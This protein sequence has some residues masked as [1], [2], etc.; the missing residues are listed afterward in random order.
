MRD[1]AT[2][3]FVVL[4]SCGWLLAQ[5]SPAPEAQPPV[6]RSDVDLVTLHVTV[7]DRNR[8][9]VRGLTADDFTVIENG[10]P[11]AIV[12]LDAIEVPTERQVDRPVWQDEVVEDVVTN[13]PS[14]GRLVVI[15]FDRSIG[16]GWATQRARL[17]AQQAIDALGPDD[18]AAV[19][20]N[21]H[22]STPVNF[23]SNRSR[24]R[25]A[26]QSPVIGTQPYEN[27]IESASCPCGLCAVDIITQVAAELRHA[28]R[29]PKMLLYIGD[30][31]PG[32]FID[33]LKHDCATYTVPATAAMFDAAQRSQLVIH[34]IETEGPL[35]P[36]HESVLQLAGETGGRAVVNTNAPEAR[37]SEIFH[38][39]TVSYLIGFTPA[40]ETSDTNAQRVAVRV[41]GDGYTV[42]APR[43]Y[44]RSVSISR[45]PPIVSAA[46]IE[47]A[48][49]LRPVHT[50]AA[51]AGLNPVSEID[52]RASVIAVPDPGTPN[53]AAVA[54]LLG[55]R[56][57]PATSGG[58][59][60]LHVQVNAFNPSGR[61]ITSDAQ[62]VTV[63]PRPGASAHT[64][65]IL[66]RLTLPPG[67]Y[68]IRAAVEQLETG[69]TG[70]VFS[71]IEIEN[72]SQFAVAVSGLALHATPAPHLISAPGADI[73]F[74]LPPTTDRTFTRDRRVT[75]FLRLWQPSRV[76][77]HDVRLTA[78]IRNAQGDTVVTQPARLAADDFDAQRVAT[79]H[80]AL[81]LDRLVAGNYL[82]SVDVRHGRTQTTRTVRFRME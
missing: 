62:T 70:S 61:L 75:A 5:Q 29:R 39:S 53:R 42:H 34:A 76:T 30:N 44:R 56:D 32:L 3:I 50:T 67:R 22:L 74:A 27:S 49:P 14:T 1:A 15:M 18:L 73:G 12:A 36:V 48:D 9:P 58:P 82:L 80:V 79:Y 16:R 26:I 78:Q 64:F 24:L 57:L 28:D 77:A 45:V 7:L 69:R 23:T 59:M 63:T 4:L 66:S 68:E 47:S 20:Y 81:P 33:D 2:L 21:Y 46:R 38:E 43:S 54:M 51:I 17:I 41:R 65:E 13:A 11:R 10:Q 25:E 31:L 19:V 6:F 72:F 40:A 55:I 52:L 71:S 60:P 8:R 35:T 37:V